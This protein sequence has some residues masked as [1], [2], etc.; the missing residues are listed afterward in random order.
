MN[1]GEQHEV[2]LALAWIVIAALCA[3]MLYRL[4]GG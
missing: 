1:R 2:T 4:L 3:A